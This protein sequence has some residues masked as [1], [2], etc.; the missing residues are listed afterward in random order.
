MEPELKWHLMTVYIYYSG[1]IIDRD[2][3]NGP[4]ITRF[5]DST[6]DKCSNP[7]TDEDYTILEYN[8]IYNCLTIASYGR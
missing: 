8:I 6:D 7:R 4:W 5:E 2:K 3:N 1:V